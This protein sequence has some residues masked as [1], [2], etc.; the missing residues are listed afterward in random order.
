M[1]HNRNGRADYDIGVRYNIYMEKQITISIDPE[2]FEIVPGYRRAIVIG[3]RVENIPSS[4]ELVKL[5]RTEE[6]IV[7]ETLNLEDERLVAWREAFSTAGIKPNKFRPS[8][9]ALIRRVLNGNDLPS[10]STLVDIGTILSLRHVLP[11]GAHSLND[12]QT[13][14]VLRP[15]TGIE[16][17][18]PFGTDL[19]E[20]IPTGEIIFTDGNLVATS[21]WAW[22]QANHTIIKPETTEFELNI[23]ALAVIP[24]E[25]LDEIIIDAK[26]LIQKYL[27]IDSE[28]HVLDSENSIVN[29]SG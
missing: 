10:I 19:A 23:D 7:R 14:L 6:A 21:K 13:E 8:I 1:Y 18:T 12:V 26:Q 25:K 24:S 20:T 11:C 15:A 3:E 29:Y 2:I 27:N 16:S 4:N 28:S 17:F 5:L 22:R 9:D